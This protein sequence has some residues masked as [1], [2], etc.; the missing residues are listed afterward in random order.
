MIFIIGDSLEK[1]WMRKMNNMY[2]N[3]QKVE[4]NKQRIE[5]SKHKIDL[6]KEVPI[7][8]TFYLYI[9]NGC[10]LACQH[11]WITPRFV[12][13]KSHPGECLELALLKIAVKKG[14]TLGLNNAKLTGG[15]PVLHPRFVDIVDYLSQENIALNME[16][17]GT[18]ITAELAK[19]LK[20]NT[21]MS[22]IST[23]LDSPTEK[24]H[25]NFRGV[26]GA[27]KTTIKGI[28]YLTNAGFRPQI[29]MSPYHGNLHE[30]EELVKLAIKLGAGSVKFNPIS[31]MGRGKTMERN[32][33]ILN[34]EEI[35]NL[36][37]LIRSELQERYKIKLIISIPPALSSIK[38]LLREKNLGGECHV[39]NILGILGNGE[40]ALCGIGR[41]IPELCFGDLRKDDLR[42]VWMSHPTLVQLRQDL[43]GKFPGICGDCIHAKRCLTHCVAMNYEQYGKLVHPN[44]LCEE[45]DKSGNFPKNR[46]RSFPNI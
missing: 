37:H 18:L 35:L 27:F 12:N 22:F 8:N 3:E 38:E 1:Y 29:I 6:P 7:L 17:N 15:E 4:I 30:V 41:N 32:K 40:L 19:H 28:E 2:I 31:P 20:K 13:G 24:N 43:N 45:T 42:D 33:E 44:F 36:V 21:R 34:Y 39:L 26:Q 10:N 14:K 25:D 23:S 9:T 11:C 16:T 46:R 5:Y